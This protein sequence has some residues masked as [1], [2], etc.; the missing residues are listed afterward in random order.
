M[1]YTLKY[2]F[3]IYVLPFFSTN[4]LVNV[5]I[6]NYAYKGNNENECICL[7]AA[8]IGWSFI[9]V[10]YKLWA[11]FNVLKMYRDMGLFE[12]SLLGYAF[13]SVWTAFDENN[14]TTALNVPNPFLHMY[15]IPVNYLHWLPK[16]LYFLLFNGFI[17][18]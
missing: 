18:I 1:Y 3:L 8:G 2:L 11:S 12:A 5:F 17:R 10:I 14:A 13:Y 6:T 15:L 9:T 7:S 16:N 4:W